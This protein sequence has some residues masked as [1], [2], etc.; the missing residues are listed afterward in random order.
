MTPPTRLRR[1]GA[2][3]LRYA[4][5]A[6]FLLGLWQ[7]FSWKA[8]D[9]LLPAPQDA[10]GA[11][12]RAMGTL[13]FWRH[14][15]VSSWRAVAGM[16]LGFAGAYPLGLLMGASRRA[17][18]LLAPLVHLTY[19]IPKIVLLPLLLLL[20]GLGDASKICMIALILGYQVLVSVRDG[21]RG[22]DPR[23]KDAI[24]AMGGGRVSLLREV[25]LP[26]SL[27][28][29]FTALRLGTGVAVAVLFFVESF[30]TQ[31][32]LGYLIMD[33]WGR[34]DY[35]SMFIG[36]LGMSAMGV[37]LFEIVNFLERRLCRWTYAGAR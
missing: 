6:V 23:R 5:A 29:G 1:I 10:L 31:W 26:A 33:A 11:F 13:E 22:V 8:G 15:G 14:F 3:L 2:A 4:A 21:V 20:L 16:A 18:A 28:H 35:L 32:G 17:N 24:R 25:Y 7:V 37:A 12:G 19:P 27:P 36:I 34:M 9:V 30:A